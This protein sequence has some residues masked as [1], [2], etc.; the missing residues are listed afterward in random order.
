MGARFRLWDSADRAAWVDAVGGL[1]YT[2][3]HQSF[4]HDALG[5]TFTGVASRI[6]TSIG[7]A[8]DLIGARLGARGQYRFG[9][10]WSVAGGAFGTFS[11]RTSSLYASQNFTNPVF[12]NSFGGSNA[13]ASSTSSFRTH[14]SDSNTGFVPAVNANLSLNYD[15]N[16]SLS[17]GVLY[18]FRAMFNMT[19]VD[20]PQVSSSNPAVSGRP[21]VDHPLRLKDDDRIIGNF[22]GVQATLKF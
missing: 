19:R 16:D 2:H 8:D 13:F 11:Y 20:A 6:S 12:V 22:A 21:V 7:I 9:G 17:I 18:Q 4:D 15:L 10:A 14:V 5:N 3:G 1:A